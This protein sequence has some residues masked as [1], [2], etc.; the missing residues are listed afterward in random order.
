MACESGA[1]PVDIREGAKADLGAT[2]H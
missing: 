2:I 1:C